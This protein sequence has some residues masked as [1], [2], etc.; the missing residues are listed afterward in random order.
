MVS[1]IMLLLLRYFVEFAIDSHVVEFWDPNRAADN[2]GKDGGHMSRASESHPDCWICRKP[3]FG[4]KSSLSS[5]AYP[6]FRS[7]GQS[8]FC[9]KSSVLS[10]FKPDFR[11]C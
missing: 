6:D 11:F 1:A 10:E 7:D 8:A 4:R 2:G 3:T 5:G 9:W